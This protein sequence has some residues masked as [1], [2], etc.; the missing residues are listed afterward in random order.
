MSAKDPI[1]N[2]P[3][4]DPP[5]L[6]M[7][8]DGYHYQSED[9]MK[10]LTDE[11]LDAIAGPSDY[12]DGYVAIRAAIAADRALNAADRKTELLQQAHDRAHAEVMR[13]AERLRKYEPG[14]GMHLNSALADRDVMRQAPEGWKLVPIEPTDAMKERGSNCAEY[15]HDDIYPESAADVYRAMLAVAPTPPAEQ[16]TKVETT[17]AR[18]HAAHEAELTALIQERDHRE[19]IIDD[20]CDA[21]LGPDRAEW[22]S[23]YYFEDAVSEVQERIAELEDRKE[24]RD[25]NAQ[26]EK[27]EPAPNVLA[28]L[29]AKVEGLHSPRLGNS[30]ATIFRADVLALIDKM[31]GKV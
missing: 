11:Q 27:Q 18:Q 26:A 4:P 1:K 7:R 21:V 6:V 9:E 24:C 8:A 28:T 29:R 20:L 5:E 31:G 19:E 12:F 10:D 22:S 15:G 3:Q 14:N 17:Y 30:N 16:P 13:L 25:S 2:C 23:A